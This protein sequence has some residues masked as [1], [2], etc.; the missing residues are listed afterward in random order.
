[1]SFQRL[2]GRARYSGNGLG[3]AICQRIT[4]LHGGRIWLESEPE[5]GSRFHFLLPA[6][7]LMT[8]TEAS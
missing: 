8:D 2:Y 4:E 7:P 3:L 5:Q 1:M 6:A